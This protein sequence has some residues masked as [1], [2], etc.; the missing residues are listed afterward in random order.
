[1]SREPTLTD[2]AS[3]E[4]DTER[5]RA[6]VGDGWV[7]APDGAHDELRLVDVPSFVVFARARAVDRDRRRALRCA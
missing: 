1:M 2:G 7:E 5:C 4:L 3:D 6:A